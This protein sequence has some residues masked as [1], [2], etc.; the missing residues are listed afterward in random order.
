MHSCL[1]LSICEGEFSLKNLCLNGWRFLPSAA[2]QNNKAMGKCF[3]EGVLMSTAHNK[4]KSRANQTSRVNSNFYVICLCCFC[5]YIYISIQ[6]VIASVQSFS[7]YSPDCVE[8]NKPINTSFQDNRSEGK[9]KAFRL[10]FHRADGD[11]WYVCHSPFWNLKFFAWSLQS[12]V[13]SVLK[14][15]NWLKNWEWETLW[16]SLLILRHMFAAVLK[17]KEQQ[18]HQKMLTKSVFSMLPI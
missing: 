6:S 1:K 13:R 16:S 18:K 11:Y 15:S 14:Q 12:F 7:W 8:Q 5:Q 9:N 17:V 10:L 2:S 3:M 4:L